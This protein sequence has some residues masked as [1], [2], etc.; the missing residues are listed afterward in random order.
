MALNKN[1]WQILEPPIPD[2][3]ISRFGKCTLTIELGRQILEQP[4]RMENVK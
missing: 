1:L 3:P 2:R 4:G